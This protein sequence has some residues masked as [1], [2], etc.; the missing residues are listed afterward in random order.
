MRLEAINEATVDA[1]FPTPEQQVWPGRMD[2]QRARGGATCW[3]P[4]A[5]AAFRW[6][7]IAAAVALGRQ[8]E[9]WGIAARTTYTG[10]RTGKAVDQGTVAAGTDLWMTDHLELAIGAHASA[11]LT[12]GQATCGEPARSAAATAYQASC[13]PCQ[14][15]GGSVCGLV[16]GAYSSGL[17]S[18]G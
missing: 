10:C 2:P 11:V 15:S 14:S 4:P 3:N 8:P 16:Q 17:E 18:F 6:A 5:A 9:C 13:A 12:A 7:S 1:L